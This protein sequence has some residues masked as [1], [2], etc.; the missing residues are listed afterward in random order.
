[1]AMFDDAAV[2]GRPSWFQRAVGAALGGQ[3]AVQGLWSLIGLTFMSNVATSGFYSFFGVWA[4]TQLGGTPSEIGALLLVNA[5]LALL[6]GY[7]GGALSDRVGRKLVLVWCLAGQA[8][9]VGSC[10]LVGNRLLVGFA[11]VIVAS[12]I[13][14][15]AWAARTSLVSDLVRPE[16]R[17][18]AFST[19]R[20]VTNVAVVVSPALV[21]ALL[22]LAGWTTVFVL[23]GVLGLGSA[24]YAQLFVSNVRVERAQR[25]HK[26]RRRLAILSDRP[27]LLM[28]VATLLAL[29]VYVAYSTVLPIVV[30]SRYGYSAAT[31]GFLACVNPVVVILSQGWL[32]RSV[33]H[34]TVEVRVAVGTLLM[35]L[36]WSLLLLGHS[37]AVIVAVILLFVCGEMFWAPASQTTSADLA[38]ETNRGAYQGA[39]GSVMSIAFAVG[40]VIALSV[41]GAAGTT[42]MWLCLAAVSVVAALVGYTATRAGRRTLS[43]STPSSSAAVVSVESV[44]RPVIQAE[45]AETPPIARLRQENE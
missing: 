16:Q 8:I 30:V 32:T 9:A 25:S 4:I 7:L 36:P 21:G 45:L 1:M 39:Y 12:T 35:G 42:A 22:A 10:A 15:P 24:V 29:F 28:L 23:L 3:D 31:W 20:T 2:P 6:S 38:P 37:I 5:A 33:R 41:L 34:R 27:Y 17:S 11:L 18:M 43:A 14:T 44:L 26:A 13:G 19:M 40:P